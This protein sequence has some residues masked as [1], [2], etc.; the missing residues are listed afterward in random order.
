MKTEELNRIHKMMTCGERDIIILGGTLLIRY[1]SEEIIQFL[2]DY[3]EFDRIGGELLPYTEYTLSV[4]HSIKGDDVVIQRIEGEKQ[5]NLCLISSGFVHEWIYVGK[6]T[7]F[8]NE[9]EYVYI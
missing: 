4:T 1:S 3:G 8:Y 9:D 6:L 5:H 2:E 7:E